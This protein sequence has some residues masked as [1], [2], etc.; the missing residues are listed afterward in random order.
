VGGE[1]IPAAAD[2]PPIEV[3]YEP[4]ASV[5]TRAAFGTALAKLGAV[6]P[7]VVV[8]DGDVGNSTGTLAFAKDRSERFI[9]AYI[10]EQNMAGMAMGLAACGKRPV[11][12]SFAAFLTRAADFIRMASHSGCRTS[13]FAAATSASPSE[14]TGRRRWVWKI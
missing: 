13:S 3:H 10:A 12:A 5:A 14:R 8:I 2:V 1:R 4:G 11:A 9:Q 6:M 7:D